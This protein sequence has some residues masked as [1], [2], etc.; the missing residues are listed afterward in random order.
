MTGKQ[1]MHQRWWGRRADQSS[2]WQ[3]D[4][5]FMW[6]VVGQAGRCNQ[7]PCRW[8]DPVVSGEA[9]GQMQNKMAWQAAVGCGT[10][11]RRRTDG[12]MIGKTVGACR[13][14][15]RGELNAA[16]MPRHIYPA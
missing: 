9:G 13:L 11:A 3:A 2:P 4:A 12:V 10:H 5:C 1:G 8:V 16:C 14:Y 7:A 15:N 6:S